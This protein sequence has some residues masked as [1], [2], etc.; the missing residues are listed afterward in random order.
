VSVYVTGLEGVQANLLKIGEL[1]GAAMNTAMNEIAQM[2]EEYAKQN[3]PWVNQTGDTEASITGAV[4][5]ATATEIILSLSA[6]MPYDVFLELAHNGNWA[7]LWPSMTANEDQILNLLRD[8]G[9]LGL[10]GLSAVS[11][12]LSA[13]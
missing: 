12:S 1:M 5:K 2:L 9:V 6:G 7:W 10:K 8:H 13:V 11:M 4:V 3:H